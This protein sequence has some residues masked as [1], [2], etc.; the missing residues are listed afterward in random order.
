[1]RRVIVMVVGLGALLAACSGSEPAIE[2]AEG[3]SGPDSHGFNPASPSTIAAN[4]REAVRI[5]A[6]TSDDEALAVRGFIGRDENL[7]I[8]DPD[9][10]V[11][12]RAA[13]YDFLSE[14][15]VASVHPGSGGRPA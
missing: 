9:G 10:G 4:R 13:D 8:R 7:E 15:P 11:I 14:P 2:L 5:G 6:I 3:S 1:M 12:W